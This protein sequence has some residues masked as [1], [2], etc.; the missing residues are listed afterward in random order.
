[1]FNENQ[2]MTPNIWLLILSVDIIAYF[3][4]KFTLLPI[5]ALNLALAIYKYR[6]ILKILIETFPRDAR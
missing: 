3:V 2:I 5:V 6:Q 4:L 1:M